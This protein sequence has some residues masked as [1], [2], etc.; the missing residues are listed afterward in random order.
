VTEYIQGAIALIFT[1]GMIYYVL[2]H[3]GQQLDPMLTSS[4]GIILGFYFGVKSTQNTTAKAAA[5][6]NSGGKDANG[7]PS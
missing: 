3:G 1:L 5:A 6:A 4:W 2:Q 7:N